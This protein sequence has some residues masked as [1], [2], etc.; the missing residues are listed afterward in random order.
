MNNPPRGL[1]MGFLLLLVLWAM[2]S[3]LPLHFVEAQTV[4]RIEGYGIDHSDKSVVCFTSDFPNLRMDDDP[5]RCRVA[6]AKWTGDYTLDEKE[7]TLH[8]NNLQT[9]SPPRHLLGIG[10]KVTL[11]GAT[12]EDGTTA[13]V[14]EM[15][16]FQGQPPKEQLYY[17][18]GDPFDETLTIIPADRLPLDISVNRRL[19]DKFLRPQGL[20]MVEAVW[21]GGDFLTAGG[22]G[23][24]AVKIRVTGEQDAY[25][26]NLR[27]F[28]DER[29]E[30]L[31]EQTSYIPWL[32]AGD[33]T[34][35]IF[36]VR[37][38]A[39][40]QEGVVVIKVAVSGLGTSGNRAVAIQTSPAFK[41]GL[42]PNLFADLAFE[43]GNQNG[44]LEA[45]ESAALKIR[46][47]NEGKG[48]AQGLRVAVKNDDPAESSLEIE[49]KRISSIGPGDSVT[50]TIAL[51][52]DVNLKTAEHRLAIEVTEHFGY[53]MDPAY[54]VL[55][56]REYVKPTLDFRGLEIVDTGEG[57]MAISEDGQLQGGEWAKVRLVVQ[58]VGSGLAKNVKFSVISS[59]P[60]IYLDDASGEL[61]D[62]DA[63]QTKEIWF[64]I[65]PNKRVATGSPLPIYLSVTE[66]VGKGSL[67]QFRIPLH[68]GQRPPKVEAVTIKPDLEFLKKQIARFEFTSQRFSTNLGNPIDV[69]SVQPSKTKRQKS[70]AVVFGVERYE[71]LPSAPFAAHDAELMKEY[72]EK[73]LGVEHVELYRDKD[74]SGFVLERV[75]DPDVGDLQRGIVRG[76]TELF[77]YYSGHGIPGKS[78]D[79]TYLFPS[80]GRKARLNKEGYSLTK[81][82]E[83]LHKLGAKSVTVI[84]DACFSGGS[85][86][87]ERIRTENLV[88]MKG[89]QLKV[90]KPW[91]LYDNFT[92][93][94]SSTGEE[95]SLGYDEAQTGLFTYYLAAGLQGKADGNG[96]R[97]ITLGE[98]KK[99]VTMNVMETSRKISGLQTPEFWGNDSNVLVEY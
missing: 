7:L 73:R 60:N 70:V 64:V 35:S 59:D 37:G 12:F 62:M 54:L 23:N 13:K 92:V 75:F 74:V 4:V 47:K 51:E 25:G 81:F 21:Q 34:T 27:A 91:L 71:E 19:A 67:D 28:A 44:I 16:Q 33:S 2:Q 87:T 80:D 99:Y 10:Y 43:D 22:T 41:R 45:T 31:S 36:P 65:S 17:L 66:E 15:L 69:K 94:N 6:N 61:G 57:T 98:L 56:T 89:V 42:P 76:E 68:L 9:E 30:F 58:N 3:L 24:V 32:A 39:Q 84:L 11:S 78:G 29:V 38:I 1:S 52:T 93:I 50:L 96:D 90:N 14:I 5:K 26:I 82:Y 88:A 18:T 48:K 72:F 40:L 86:A 77:V 53:D 97:K 20:L 83:N 63:G 55:N 95:T 85:R 46:L 79:E 49:D 8:I